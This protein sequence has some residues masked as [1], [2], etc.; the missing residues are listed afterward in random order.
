MKD[1]RIKRVSTGDFNK[2]RKPLVPGSAAIK[3]HRKGHIARLE[4]NTAA[5]AEAF[6]LSCKN[7]PPERSGGKLVFLHLPFGV[8]KGRKTLAPGNAGTGRNT[9]SGQLAL[10]WPYHA[11]LGPGTVQDL[12]L[13]FPA[14][15]KR[16]EGPLLP[17]RN[18][19]GLQ[20]VQ[21]RANGGLIIRRPSFS[22][23]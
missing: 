14:F 13:A 23:P 10:Q 15:L 20:K 17:A 2:D 6:R 11:S 7:Y 8:R 3:S 18:Q 9:R 19:T 16:S 21:K 12:L 5:G 22:K 1:Q 4:R